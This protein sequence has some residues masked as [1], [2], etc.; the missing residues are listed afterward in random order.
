MPKELKKVVKNQK[1][2]KITS[3]EFHALKKFK[4]CL[5]FTTKENKNLVI[6]RQKVFEKVC[7]YKT[8]IM[9]Q[10]ASFL[11]IKYSKKE[12]RGNKKIWQRFRVWSSF[13]NGVVKKRK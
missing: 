10:F 1:S 2:I 13:H 5:E 11:K 4:G 9:P 8:G 3:S 12:I 6:F 7:S